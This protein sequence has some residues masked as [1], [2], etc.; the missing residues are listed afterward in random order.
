[1]S[2]PPLLQLLTDPIVQAGSLAL[3]GAFVTHVVLRRHPTRRL[4]GQ[5][6]FFAALTILLLYHGIVPYEAGPPESFVLQR[7]FIGFAKVIWWANAAWALAGFA[8]VFLIFE[9]QPREGRLIQDL[10]VGMIYTGTALSVVANVFS[11]PVG[12]L[13]ATSGVFAII[14]GLAMQSTLSDVFSGIALNIGR[15]YA[16]GDW[17]VLKDG[18]EGRVIETNWRAT[19]LV[20]STN[21]LVVLPNSDL[22][23][24]RLT[25]LSSPDHSHGGTLT[26]RLR[27]TTRPAAVCDLI[28]TVMLSCTAILPT[29][30]PS[31]RILSIDAQ[32]IEVQLSFWVAGRASMAK[33]QNELFDLIYRH[34]KAA[35][36]RLAPPPGI[37]EPDAGAADTASPQRRTTPLRLLDALP[38]FAPLTEAEKE[39]LA[40]TMTRRTYRKGEIVVAQGASLGAL[41]IVRSGVLVVVHQEKDHEVELARLAPGDCFGEGGLLMGAGEAGT[42]RA[43]TFVVA[44]AIAKDSLAPLLHDRPGITEELAAALAKRAATE[45]HLF[46]HAEPT[47]DGNP[48]PWMVTRIRQLFQPPH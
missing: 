46:H 32:A 48:V 33:V 13:I 23:K 4:I 9:R 30:E 3:I 39:A 42:I 38:L 29:P 35:G 26:V 15:P 5:V 14:L 45:K 12:T 21:D 19:Y 18:I 37:G 16:I 24:A 11:V 36:L 2:E 47:T 44:Y 20:N 25:N 34:S 17:I 40:G 1:M 8:R 10:V 7:V 27:L 6:L 28:R 43:L 31:V 22:A 41:M